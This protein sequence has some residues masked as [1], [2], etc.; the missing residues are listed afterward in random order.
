RRHLDVLDPEVGIVDRAA[1]LLDDRL[2]QLEAVADRPV[3]LVEE[4]EG[5]RGLA[6]A[7]PHGVRLLDVGQRRAE[8][9]FL[10]RRRAGQEG[11]PQQQKRAHQ[12]RTGS[13]ATW[14]GGTASSELISC[15]GASSPSHLATTEVA[16]ELPITLVALRPMS[17]KV[18]MPMIISSPASGMLNWLSVAAITTSEARGTPATPLEVIISVASMASCV[19]SAIS[20]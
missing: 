3:G 5:R 18:S 16:S 9:D 1:D 11:Q 2:A 7:E 15:S 8:P 10:R 6:I 13:P 19:P 12:A 4:R 20:M 17:R 14:S